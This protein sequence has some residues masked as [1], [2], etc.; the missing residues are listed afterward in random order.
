[1]NVVGLAWVIL[2]P[3]CTGVIVGSSAR[4]NRL[5]ARNLIASCALGW[6][7]LATLVVAVFAVGGSTATLVALAVAP[8]VGLAFWTAAPGRG[9]DGPA[10]P[11]PPDDHPSS[12]E[13]VDW[14]E[15]MRELG[16]WS[17]PPA[18]VA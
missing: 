3:Y 9:G 5:V 15:F 13:R 7:A 8:L 4:V 12:D 2:T 18:G 6:I 11:E 16:E 1:M 10:P 14:D 17:R